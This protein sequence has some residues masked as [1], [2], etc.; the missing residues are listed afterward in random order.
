MGRRRGV[1]VILVTIIFSVFDK[2]LF[3]SKQPHSIYFSIIKN[4]RF[5]LELFIS[6]DI[7]WEYNTSYIFS[8]ELIDSSREPWEYGFA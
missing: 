5:F 3:I 6:R 7:V 2:A 4:R 1:A 8:G